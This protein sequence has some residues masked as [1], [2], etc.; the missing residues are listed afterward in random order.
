MGKQEPKGERKRILVISGQS[1]NATDRKCATL[2][3]LADE[4]A[5][6]G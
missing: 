3:V 5:H 1:E 2:V 4:E 6:D